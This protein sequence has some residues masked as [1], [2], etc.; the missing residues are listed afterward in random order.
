MA[1]EQP[2]FKVGAKGKSA[3]AARRQFSGQVGQLPCGEVSFPSPRV[4]VFMASGAQ[5]AETRPAAASP[6]WPQCV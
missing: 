4:L 1:E 6:P 5:M 2:D 3:V